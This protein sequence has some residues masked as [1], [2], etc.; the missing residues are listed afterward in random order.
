MP[1]ARCSSGGISDES[2]FWN[3]DVAN[4]NIATSSP[5][6]FLA[7]MFLPL[8]LNRSLKSDAFFPNA[9]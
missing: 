9:L 3:A 4:A 5:F 8:G 1:L 7:N 6:T 2:F